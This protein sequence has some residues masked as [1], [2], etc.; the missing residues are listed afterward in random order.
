MAETLEALKNALRIADERGQKYVCATVELTRDDMR[1]AIEEL[2]AARASIKELKEREKQ[3]C[4]T[5]CSADTSAWGEPLDVTLIASA[6]R[7]ALNQACDHIDELHTVITMRC[8]YHYGDEG[9]DFPEV[10]H[11]CIGKHG[12]DTTKC[13]L[14]EAELKA[15]GATPTEAEGWRGGVTCARCKG[16][17]PRDTTYIPMCTYPAGTDEESLRSCIDYSACTERWIEANT[18]TPAKLPV[19][20]CMKLTNN[21]TPCILVQGHVGH[22]L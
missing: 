1:A 8:P 21:E 5:L 12:W 17:V 2:Q 11:A 15:L 6:A 10:T 16:R 18:W 7:V 20:Q 9:E 3:V 22:H 13:E 14:T 4:L 19:L